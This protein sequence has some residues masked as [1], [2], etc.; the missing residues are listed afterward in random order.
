MKF[1]EK[2]CIPTFFLQNFAYFIPLI[3][4]LQRYQSF[5][6]LCGGMLGKFLGGNVRNGAGH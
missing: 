6:Q 4:D 5:G 2:S 1:D 3:K